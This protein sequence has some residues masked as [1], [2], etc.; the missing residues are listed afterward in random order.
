MLAFSLSRHSACGSVQL[1]GLFGET[2]FCF[3]E[4]SIVLSSY[5]ARTWQ[6]ERDAWE[7]TFTKQVD[8]VGFKV[9][10]LEL[11]TLVEFLGDSR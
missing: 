5:I 9:R 4:E 2:F 6:V 8:I 10:H 11:E 7:D 3:L 1:L